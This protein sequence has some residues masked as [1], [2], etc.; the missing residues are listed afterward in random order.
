MTVPADRR[1]LILFLEGIWGLRLA[2]ISRTLAL[3]S[4]GRGLSFCLSA[5]RLAGRY[6]RVRLGSLR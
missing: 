1:G 4:A 5:G 2:W 3:T 6:I